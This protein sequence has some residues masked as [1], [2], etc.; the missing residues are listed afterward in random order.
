[1]MADESDDVK[2]SGAVLRDAEFGVK[3]RIWHS[4]NQVWWCDG[5]ATVEVDR[6]LYVQPVHP[7]CFPLHIA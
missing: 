3:L 5:L 4:G 2:A 7:A 6:E 1:M